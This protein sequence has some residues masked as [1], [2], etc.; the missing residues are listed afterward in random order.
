[1][2]HWITSS[3]S[4]STQ[5]GEHFDAQGEA[6]RWNDKG[7][8]YLGFKDYLTASSCF[9]M[10]LRTD[11]ES[12]EEELYLANLATAQFRL[13]LYEKAAQGFTRAIDLAPTVYTHYICLGKVFLRWGGHEQ[14][15]VDILRQAIEIDPTP[16]AL[17]L[18]AKANGALQSRLVGA[19]PESAG[20]AQGSGLGVSGWGWDQMEG[21]RGTLQRRRTVAVMEAGDG[22]DASPE[23]VR[24]A[25]ECEEESRTPRAS[26]RGQ[27][28]FGAPDD[29]VFRSSL[30]RAAT[31]QVVEA[32]TSREAPISAAQAMASRGMAFPA[33]GPGD[34]PLISTPARVRGNRQG[35]LGVGQ[36]APAAA[37]VGAIATPFRTRRASR[38][39]KKVELWWRKVSQGGQDI[40]K[41]VPLLPLNR[42]KEGLAS[43]PVP[44][45]CLSPAPSAHSFSP[46]T[47]AVVPVPTT[48]RLKARGGIGSFDE[49]E[50]EPPTTPKGE[51]LVEER[52]TLGLHVPQQAELGMM[53]SWWE[54]VTTFDN[55]ARAQERQQQQQQEQQEQQVQQWPSTAR[56]S[57]GLTGGTTQKDSS[58]S[59]EGGRGTRG[60]GNNTRGLETSVKSGLLPLDGGHGTPD[61][62]APGGPKS[63][64]AEK[65][66]AGRG[67]EPTPPGTPQQVQAASKGS[68]NPIE[69]WWQNLFGGKSLGQSPDGR[70]TRIVGRASLGGGLV[71]P[72]AGGSSIPGGEVDASRVN[73]GRHDRG[74]G[75][76]TQGGARE[77]SQGQE[78]DGR[79]GRV[80]ELE[81]MGTLVVPASA[82]EVKEAERGGGVR[83]VVEEREAVTVAAVSLPSVKLEEEPLKPAVPYQEAGECQAGTFRERSPSMDMQA[84]ALGV[85]EEAVSLLTG[86]GVGDSSDTEKVPTSELGGRGSRAAAVA[87]NTPSPSPPPLKRNLSE[88][89]RR[90]A[91]AQRPPDL[92]SIGSSSNSMASPAS[93][94]MMPWG[95]PGDVGSPAGTV[96]TFHQVALGSPQDQLSGSVPQVEEDG[97][98]E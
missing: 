21:A 95:A 2:D 15:A 17:S 14:Q 69:T 20:R 29:G 42:E 97:Q 93:T 9:E 40:D 96:F 86:I 38:E 80:V 98:E 58:L 61:D 87:A 46:A 94:E 78:N 85:V 6:A 48:P 23:R 12:P 84:K 89:R 71:Q 81:T 67:V 65:E 10:A 18:A 90:L 66:V 16:T 72:Q 76:R 34:T 22:L 39:P 82:G 30:G 36:S 79:D 49:R 35:P 3:G 83:G 5:G 43:A 25:H 27:G 51:A 44:A 57:R 24:S 56:R 45:P 1:M 37:G 53:Q 41:D 19:L 8:L 62:R 91:G 77:A 52:A 11:P 55:Q 74:A 59:I 31:A 50:V 70:S 63:T 64:A 7:N 92:G 4:F 33:P 88:I 32:I 13:G 47:P 54:K 26:G 68:G 73:I 28:G 75:A 60:S